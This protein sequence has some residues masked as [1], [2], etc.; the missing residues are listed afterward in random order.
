MWEQGEKEEGAGGEEEADED[1]GEKAQ[2]AQAP[3]EE[4]EREQAESTEETQTEE[5]DESAASD[6]EKS[7]GGEGREERAVNGRESAK[8]GKK[9]LRTAHRLMSENQ[10]PVIQSRRTSAISA[11]SS[12]AW[13]RPVL[14]LSDRDNATPKPK[15]RP[16]R[17]RSK[18]KA[19]RGQYP[20]ARRGARVMR[21]CRFSRPTLIGAGRAIVSTA[22]LA[23]RMAARAPPCRA[24]SALPNYG[25]PASVLQLRRCAHAR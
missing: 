5:E 12:V 13:P 9:S 21:R 8:A 6:E 2:K 22:K 23:C 14:C 19:G 10:L 20:C 11:F 15:A 18:R 1:T 17:A 4:E 25:R 16:R 24:M 7:K 3:Q